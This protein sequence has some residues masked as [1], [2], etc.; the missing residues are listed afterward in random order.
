M[1]EVTSS[2]NFPILTMAYL[3]PTIH[4]QF[5][6]SAHTDV[7]EFQKVKKFTLEQATKAQRG[8]EV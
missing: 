7:L 8:E 2:S 3:V 1:Y 6:G 4:T 5:N